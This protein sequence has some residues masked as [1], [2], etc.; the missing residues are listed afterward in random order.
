MEKLNLYNITDLN[1]NE[2]TSIDG[3]GWL[4]AYL[5]S[6]PYAGAAFHFGIGFLVGSTEATQERLQL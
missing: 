1:P 5:T 3:G 2:L 4:A 6:N